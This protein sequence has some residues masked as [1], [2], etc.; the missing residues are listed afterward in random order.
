MYKYGQYCPVARATEILGERWTLLIIRDFLTGTKHFNELVRGL[1]GISRALLVQR[2]DSLE[3]EGVIE[4]HEIDR[5]KQSSEYRLT[6]AG[7]EL[8]MVIESLLEWGAKWAFGDPRPEEL[9]PV[10]LLWWMRQRVYRERLPQERVV[11]Q[12]DFQGAEQ[13]SYWLILTKDDV[14]VCLKY[15]GFHIDVL[16]TADLSTFYQVWLGR[17]HFAHAMRTHRIEVEAIPA[18]RRVFPDL[19]ALSQGAETVRTVSAGSP[20]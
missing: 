15:P 3:K 14:S 4:K 18:L 6:E 9:D 16:V 13:E 2:L 8:V 12:F 7:E 17:I 10:L 20:A 19:F 1:P 5:G 11:V